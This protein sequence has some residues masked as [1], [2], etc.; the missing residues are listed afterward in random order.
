[1]NNKDITENEILS[2]RIRSRR[3]KIRAQHED[4]EKKLIALHKERRQLYQQQRS[5]GWVELHPPVMRGWKRYFVLR[6]DVQRSKSAA[7]FT[8]ILNRI[9]TVQYSSLKDFKVKKRK[10]GRK[11]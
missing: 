8:S 1:M 4:L 7:F 2:F 10:S 5:L 11:I 3:Q 9:N 6:E